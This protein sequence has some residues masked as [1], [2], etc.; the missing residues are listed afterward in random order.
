MALQG[1]SVKAGRALI[2]AGPLRVLGVA[3]ALTMLSFMSGVAGDLTMIDPPR[4]GERVVLRIPP[5]LPA[6]TLRAAPLPPLLA[7]ATASA[8]TPAPAPRTA[9]RPRRIE[10]APKPPTI[11]VR[12]EPKQDPDRAPKPAIERPRKGEPV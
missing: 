2:L 4:S 10:P 7:S 3:L 6:D 9:P 11:R 1:D 5:E 12:F 8:A